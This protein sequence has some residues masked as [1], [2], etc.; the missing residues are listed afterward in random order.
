M[1][2]GT[3]RLEIIPALPGSGLE[4]EEAPA[5][6][7]Q[8]TD[9]KV[10]L[11]GENLPEVETRHGRPALRFDGTTPV[12][13]ISAPV[14]AELSAGEAA[15]LWRRRCLHC[16]HFRQEIGNATLTIWDR[17]PENSERKR[18][19]E[20]MVTQYAHACSE[21]EPT[22]V[23]RAVARRGLLAHWGVC[24][25]LTEER[26]DVIFV[27]PGACCPDGVLYFLPRDRQS[28]QKCSDAF[29]SIMRMAQGRK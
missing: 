7:V 28:E 16:A 15:S 19:F 21:S 18:G 26:K 2:D 23:D 14:T 6:H 25:A 22:A 5:R 12:G 17:A 1:S 11:S 9:L 29:D 24:V 3:D 20:S 8:S 13:T 27:H 10:N 4:P